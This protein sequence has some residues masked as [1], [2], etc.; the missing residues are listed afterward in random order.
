MM[1]AEA[2]DILEDHA[3]AADTRHLLMN[4]KNLNLA[5][6]LSY[7]DSGRYAALVSSLR[8]WEHLPD[9]KKQVARLKAT[10]EAAYK[11]DK[12]VEAGRP[13]LSVEKPVETASAFIRERHPH[14]KFTDNAWL[15]YNGRFYHVVEERAVKAS[16]QEFMASGVDEETGADLHP[17]Q[18]PVE[19]ALDAVKNQTFRSI[20]AAEPP[21]WEP[22][23]YI[24]PDPRM[25]IATTNGI[26]DL[27]SGTLLPHSPRLFTRTAVNYAF[28][29]TAP[30]PTGFLAFLESIW[31]EAEG[32]AENKAALQEMVGYLLTGMTKFQK[33]FLLVGAPNAG[34]G[35]LAKVIEAL[36]GVDNVVSQSVSKLGSPFG[37]KALLGK[38]VMVVPDLRF[39]KNDNIGGITEAILNI[40]GEDRTNISRKYLDDKQ[41]RLSVR[42]V[43]MSNMEVTLPDQSGALRRRLFPLV[44]TKNFEGR[45]DV[46]LHDKLMAELPGILNWALAGLRRLEERRDATTG[47]QVGFVLTTEGRKMV[48]NIAR[49]GSPVHSF[50]REA[51]T[52]RADGQTPKARLFDAFE[53]WYREGAGVEAHHTEEM[54]ARELHV[55]SGY[56]IDSCKPRIDGRQVPHFKGVV[57]KPEWMNFGY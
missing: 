48:N 25:C 55:A 29:P 37:M 47:R 9:F 15:D 5:A 36:V 49:R 3:A 50:L 23:D 6:K 39:G 31:P 41:A 57:L 53:Q 8:G 34:K 12:A 45:E 35:V 14:L 46:T 33:V 20:D 27:E 54:F 56:A 28:E 38:T 21:V 40:S 26:L 2:Y 16:L 42:L 22:I 43:L 13:I 51:C 32:G 24:D 30:E 44:F 18:R 19:E 4:K 17:K 52:L 1:T 7:V 10:G 11:R